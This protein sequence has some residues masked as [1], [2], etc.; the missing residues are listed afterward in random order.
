[1]P[2]SNF[3]HL[4]VMPAAG[5][6]GIKGPGTITTSVPFSP[7][8]AQLLSLALELGN[9]KP[10]VAAPAEVST[11]SDAQAAKLR[12]YQVNPDFWLPQWVRDHID[13][14]GSPDALIQKVLDRVKATPN[15]PT[16]LEAQTV[17]NA[18]GRRSEGT[19]AIRSAGTKPVI[20]Q[21]VQGGK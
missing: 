14:K 17:L 21:V 8:G 1:M 9:G 15:A 6:I 5:S 12:Q 13:A 11:F 3:A 18:S 20:R 2:W 10:A 7:A 19:A 16:L 4:T